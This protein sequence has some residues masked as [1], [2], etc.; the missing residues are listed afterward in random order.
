VGGL[1]AFPAGAEVGRGALV[2]ALIYGERVL[3][4]SPQD[5]LQ[6]AGGV[7]SLQ[8]SAKRLSRI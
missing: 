2:L 3:L 8:R 1:A 4:L 5:N 6:L 7:A